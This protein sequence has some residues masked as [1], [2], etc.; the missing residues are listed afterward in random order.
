MRKT[1]FDSDLTGNDNDSK[2]VMGK[3][4]SKEEE[5]PL[6]RL[7]NLDEKIA[8]AIQKVKIL[9]EEKTALEKR[10]KDLEALLDD[11]NQEIER[12]SSEK[13]NIKSQIGDLLNELEAI[14]L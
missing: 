5:K 11:K 1:L 12:L 13:V 3:T 10:V 9:K 4:S 14:E 6:D 2:Y 8:D 7:K